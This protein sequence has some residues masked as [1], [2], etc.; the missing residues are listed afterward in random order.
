M[1]GSF[2]VDCFREFF[3]GFVNHA[4]VTLH[5]DHAAWRQRHHVA[6]TCFKA[7]GRALRMPWRRIR[8]WR[9]VRPQGRALSATA[10]RAWQG[11]SSSST[12]AWGTC[13]PWRRPSST[14]RATPRCWSRRARLDPRGRAG[15]VPGQG[16]AR[17]CMRAIGE[18]HLNQA[19][20]DAAATKPFLGICMG[21]QVLL[22]H[23]EENG[24]TSL[25]GLYAGEV[26][27]FPGTARGADGILSRSRRWAGTACARPAR[28]AVGGIEP[29]SRF[30]FVHSTYADPVDRTLVGPR[31]ISADYASAIPAPRVRGAVPPQ[32]S[33]QAGL[34]LLENFC[35]WQ[36]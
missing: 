11:A 30:Y 28:T 27:R 31:P 33:A 4:A 6:E 36:P 17:D 1:I 32:K 25:L 16:A 18:H 9:R 23:S 20:R 15:G 34:R 21:M 26:R 3:Q 12:T 24:G 7:F 5:V 29:G 19:I 2:D 10:G 8:G 14:W 13:A 22:E 35:R